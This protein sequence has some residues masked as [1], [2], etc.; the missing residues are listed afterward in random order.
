MTIERFAFG[1]HQ[2]N[3]R[4]GRVLDQP[5]Q[6]GNIFGLDRH[7]LVI[8]RAIAIERVAAGPAAERFA[9]CDVTDAGGRQRRRKR[10]LRKP[11]AETRVWRTAHV[12]DRLRSGALQQLQKVFG[13]NV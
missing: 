6:A 3:A 5:I 9:H 1:A 2:A 11:R 4:V 10:L 8:G 7:G 12:G 13:R